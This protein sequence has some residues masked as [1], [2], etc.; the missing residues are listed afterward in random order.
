MSGSGDEGTPSLSTPDEQYR[1]QCEK[2]VYR[3]ERG[4]E[5]LT[6]S[7]EDI[8]GALE[9]DEEAGSEPDDKSR[10]HLN[11]QLH[12][13]LD[14]VAQL[15]KGTK[16][17]SS[18]MRNFE[19]LTPTGKKSPLSPQEEK[20]ERSDSFY[21]GGGRPPKNKSKTLTEKE[22][23]EKVAALKDELEALEDEKAIL[24]ERV[25]DQTKV[26]RRLS[27]EN[28]HLKKENEKL[29]AERPA[30]D[31][32]P[33]TL[34]AHCQ[35]PGDKLEYLVGQPG[36]TV[37][38]L[39]GDSVLHEDLAGTF[40]D[41]PM[42]SFFVNKL[43]EMIV[44]LT[45]DDHT[46][47]QA[48]ESWAYS[49]S[50]MLTGGAGP[51]TDG[52]VQVPS[53]TKLFSYL[54]K[55]PPLQPG[56]GTHH[57][58]VPTPPY[59]SPNLWY[60]VVSFLFHS[61]P[62]EVSLFLKD[63][64]EQVDKLVNHVG[65]EIALNLLLVALNVEAKLEQ[66]GDEFQWSHLH[67]IPSITHKMDVTATKVNASFAAS[68]YTI[69]EESQELG[70]DTTKLESDRHTLLHD[71]S[72]LD[73]IA[74]FLGEIITKYPGSSPL[75]IQLQEEPFVRRLVKHAF[76]SYAGPSHCL[77]IINHLLQITPGQATPAVLP[78]GATLLS[79]EPDPSAAA[80]QLNIAPATSAE[81]LDFPPIIAE[82]LQE[83]PLEEDDPFLP[84]YR[85]TVHKP[86]QI[87]A[88]LLKMERLVLPSQ[89]E[90]APSPT[91]A[92][93]PPPLGMYRVKLVECASW[94]LRTGYFWVWDELIS[95]GIV[96]MWTSLFFQYP[97]NTILQNHVSSTI[98]ALLPP[99]F[100]FPDLTIL[101]LKD[102]G[103]IK[104]IADYCSVDD[105]SR[106]VGGFIGHMWAMVQSIDQCPEMLAIVKD[107]LRVHFPSLQWEA[108]TD[109]LKRKQNPPTMYAPTQAAYAPSTS[110][111]RD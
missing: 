90:D 66:Y 44:L 108:I 14:E 21:K 67:L 51:I 48:R 106:R 55:A 100:P 31:T 72:A 65:S 8:L 32:A 84:T 81:A 111:L 2:E 50:E 9:D 86:L 105:D 53:L 36:T 24:E 12:D 5:Q 85:P 87:M 27:E 110:S 89:D 62:M 40:R 16:G 35:T 92:G 10:A 46:D 70:L 69:E 107:H 56:T 76:H 80:L 3:L 4:I 58:I 91:P 45:K 74:E 61:R 28:T 83:P 71:I 7:L 6:E 37:A 97:Q 17:L 109:G 75:V 94:M 29:V 49:V 102:A 93:R 54:D 73:N 52:L 33:T 1:Q 101:L 15:K 41:E 78:S 47:E 42:L 79:A 98:A 63:R 25:S 39:F 103:L 77:S 30:K 104:K 60:K 11:K 57:T 43:D 38:Q 13:L 59:R 34:P 19:A 23:M 18:S 96:D 26:N 88:D 22:M 95:Y 82:I 68:P 99:Q 64:R 20:V